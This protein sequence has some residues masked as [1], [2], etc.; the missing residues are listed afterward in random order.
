MRTLGSLFKF[1]EVTFHGRHCR[2]LLNEESWWGENVVTG[3]QLVEAL[4]ELF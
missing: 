3:E 4:M 2:I 1:L